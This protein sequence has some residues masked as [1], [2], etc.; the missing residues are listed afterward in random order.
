MKAAIVIAME[1]EAAPLK[2]ALKDTECFSLCGFKSFKGS[3]DGGEI[4][5]IISGEGKV[6]AALAA[7]AIIN[8]FKPDVVMNFG[9]AGGLGKTPK[10]GKLVAGDVW[11]HDFDITAAGYLPGKF[12]GRADDDTAKTVVEAI[13]GERGTVATGDVFVADSA[14]A[15]QIAENFGATACEMECAGVFAAAMALNTPFVA[16]KY[17]SDDADSSAKVS[18]D[19]NVA[20]LSERIAAD[21]LVAFGALS[22][23]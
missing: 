18:M 13:G 7:M 2:A 6:N 19:E 1:S 22:G 8:F 9:I 16:V 20:P 10:G 3:A 21:I 14:R 11:E 4:A 15:K 17:I 12:R 5:A 23:K